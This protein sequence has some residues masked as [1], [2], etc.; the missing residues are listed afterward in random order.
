MPFF[1]FRA[2]Y[3][4]ARCMAMITIKRKLRKKGRDFDGAAK[5]YID[6]KYGY[7]WSY[8]SFFSGIHYTEKSHDYYDNRSHIAMKC[9]GRYRTMIS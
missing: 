7:A 2:H 6:Y 9:K 8:L 5:V 3:N 4:D 1:S